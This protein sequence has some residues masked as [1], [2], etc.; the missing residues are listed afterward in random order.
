MQIKF[1]NIAHLSQLSKEKFGLDLT[2]EINGL[3]QIYSVKKYG[4]LSTIEIF[5]THHKIQTEV[6]NSNAAEGY[7]ELLES[8]ENEVQQEDFEIYQINILSEN[9]G[10]IFFID[11]TLTQLFGVLKMNKQRIDRNVELTEK[12]ELRG[13]WTNRKFYLNG[14]ALN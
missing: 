3:L 11:L 8:L 1:R 5:S 7:D 9:S 10:Y 4:L 14:T 2:S 13:T 12:N 6:T